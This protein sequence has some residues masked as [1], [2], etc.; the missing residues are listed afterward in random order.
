ML[1]SVYGWSRAAIIIP[2]FEK[3]RWRVRK[4]N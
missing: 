2:I 1:M 4:D 3:R